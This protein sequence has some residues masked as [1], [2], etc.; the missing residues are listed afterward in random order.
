MSGLLSELTAL[1]NLHPALV[2]FPIAL[3]VTALAVDVLSL[4]FRMRERLGL[5]VALLYSMAALGGIATYL[6]GRQASDSVGQIT[7][8]AAPWG[9]VTRP[10]RA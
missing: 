10:A 5:A 9:R 1:P 8:A 7:W 4:L 3:A 6:T 2:H